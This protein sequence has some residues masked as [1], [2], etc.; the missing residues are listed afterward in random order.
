[1]A[2]QLDLSALPPASRREV[3]DFYQFLLAR[4]GKANKT[5]TTTYNFAD[6]CGG[7]SWKGDAVTAQRSIRDEW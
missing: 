3:R 2:N 6:L 7:L 4:R 1:M 5:Q